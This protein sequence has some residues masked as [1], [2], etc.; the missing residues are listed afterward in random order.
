MPLN[1]FGLFQHTKINRVLLFPQLNQLPTGNGFDQ[2]KTSSS[3]NYY[4]FF[5]LKKK[6]EGGF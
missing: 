5:F 3:R 4:Y 1:L 6:R 2:N